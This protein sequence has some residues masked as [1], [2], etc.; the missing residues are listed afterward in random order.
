MHLT[1]L[2]ED[3]PSCIFI[4]RRIN[5]LKFK[6]QE[7][8]ASHFAKYG[9]VTKVLVAHS[10]VKSFLIDRVRPGSL[11]FIVMASGESVQAILKEGK[12][13]TVAGHSINVEP[14]VRPV[15][16][17]ATSTT[18]SEPPGSGSSGSN[19]SSVQ[20]SSGSGSTGSSSENWY[21]NEFEKAVGEDDKEQGSSELAEA[22]ESGSGN[23]LAESSESGSGTECAAPAFHG[24]R[25]A[26][27]Q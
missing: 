9:T 2:L 22:S 27:K 19:G 17:R 23:Q 5:C 1:E 10:R 11:G 24:V 15:S 7:L 26:G 16:P 13:Q 21:G 4:A 12:E 20:A 6:S 18:T 8:L 25:A 3:D 14:F